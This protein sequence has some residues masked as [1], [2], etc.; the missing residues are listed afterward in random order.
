MEKFRQNEAYFPS[1]EYQK[2][3]DYVTLMWQVLVK[4]TNVNKPG[5]KIFT[6]DQ[7]GKS[8]SQK[9]ALTSQSIHNQLRNKRPNDEQIFIYISFGVLCIPLPNNVRFI[10]H[11]YNCAAYF[12]YDSSYIPFC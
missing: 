6:L 11:R 10:S 4:K 7:R 5:D 2:H 1:F 3:Q 12:I 9:A 8:P